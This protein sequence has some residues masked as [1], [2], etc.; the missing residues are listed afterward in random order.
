MS[1]CLHLL[2]I[3]ATLQPCSLGSQNTTL[4][5]KLSQSQ[6]W[7]QSGLVLPVFFF[8]G[9]ILK[10][11][12]FFIMPLNAFTIVW[13]IWTFMK[14]NTKL[15]IQDVFKNSKCCFSKPL[16][17]WTPVPFLRVIKP[18]IL[19]LS[20]LA[21]VSWGCL[22]LVPSNDPAA[23]GWQTMSF[24]SD[25]CCEDPLTCIVWCAVSIT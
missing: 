2:H 19:A 11:H 13:Y 22:L 25:G 17:P 10:Y 9:C 18:P 7:T 8:G 14:I 12:V 24:F 4:Y 1:L 3:V 20:H 6:G 16:Y 15:Y 23:L 5:S 21:S